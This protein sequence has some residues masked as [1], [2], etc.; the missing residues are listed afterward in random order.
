MN[1]RKIKTKRKTKNARQKPK[2]ETIRGK[3]KIEWR[4]RRKPKLKREWKIEKNQDWTKHAAGIK[5]G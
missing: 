5:M 2:I 1:T 3:R 4:N